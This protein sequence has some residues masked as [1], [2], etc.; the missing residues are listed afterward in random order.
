VDGK[1][2]ETGFTTAFAPNTRVPFVSGSDTFD[3]DFVS[4]SETNLGDTCAAVTS[5]SY[6]FGIVNGLLM[7]GSVRTFSSGISI[8]TWRALGIRAGGEVL[9]ELD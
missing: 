5:R 7:D 8:T 9:P 1:V 2:H 4:A 6:H 3:V